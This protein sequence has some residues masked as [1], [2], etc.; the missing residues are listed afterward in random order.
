MGN[1]E[2][3]DNII[4]THMVLSI[5]A[6]FVP[7]PILDV[8]AVTA[9]QID[10]L[11]QL[12][13][14]YSMDFNEQAGKSIISAISGSVM[15]RMGASSVKAI[16]VIGSF[17][18]G[19]TMSALSGAS[20]YAI[21]NVFKDHF[22]RG[23]DFSNIDL[24]KAKEFFKEKMEEGKQMAKDLEAQMKE[25]KNGPIS[26]SGPE[27]KSSG[28]KMTDSQV[29]DTQLH[30]SHMNDDTLAQDSVGKN[31]ASENT[32]TSNT[33]TEA[34]SNAQSGPKDFMEQL[35]AIAKMK[36]QGLLNEEEF[37]AMK[38]KIMDRLTSS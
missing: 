33:A 4:K 1:N 18:G 10:M 29:T 26:N 35:N 22:R 38:K 21:G 32:A 24:D 7:I 8:V 6:G 34:K 2:N 13:K 19:V 30:D 17:L 27:N 25:E 11:R 12:S 20:T 36:D 37:A 15:A 5:G 14:N 16:P 9:V 28:D 23:G 31:S 3:A